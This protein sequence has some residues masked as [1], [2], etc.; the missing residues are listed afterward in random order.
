MQGLTSLLQRSPPPPTN[1]IAEAR[2]VRQ[3]QQRQRRA[4]VPPSP[5]LSS[6]DDRELTSS[7]LPSS[8]AAP[9]PPASP[10]PRPLPS[11]PSDSPCALRVHA[12]LSSGYGRCLF[13]L[14]DGLGVFHSLTQLDPPLARLLPAYDELHA[15]VVALVRSLRQHSIELIV[16][17][18][19]SSTESTK[20]GEL[21]RRCQ[22][23]LDELVQLSSYL[24]HAQVSSFAP[25]TTTPPPL[26]SQCFPSLSMQAMHRQVAWSLRSQRVC[27]VQC[28]DEA[29]ARLSA[30]CRLYADAVWAVLSND[31]DCACMTGVRW[32][33]EASLTIRWVEAQPHQRH[34][35]VQVD[36]A[37]RRHFAAERSQ[38]YSRTT[39][40][41]AHA[42]HPLPDRAHAAEQS[43]PS[44][45]SGVEARPLTTPS[46][47]SPASPPSFLSRPPMLVVQWVA[48]RVWSNSAVSAA[49]RLP[50]PSLL[51]PLSVLAGNDW[52]KRLVHLWAHLQPRRIGAAPIE[53]WVHFL[54]QPQLR[55]KRLEE[56]PAFAALLQQ[57]S[58]LRRAMRHTRM[59]Y[60]GMGTEEEEQRAQ[61]KDGDGV[62]HEPASEVAAAVSLTSALDALRLRDEEL[63][64]IRRRIALGFF[65]PDTLACIVR[66]Y[67]TAHTAHGRHM[68]LL[69]L[70]L[71]H[72]HC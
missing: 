48:C 66:S 27:V 65:S 28:E 67:H 49:L 11:C 58:E 41:R 36:D 56:L 6:S 51:A 37:M 42:A 57:S 16:Y 72:S 29:D 24:D 46:A 9:L 40:P 54:T 71:M 45:W 70:L 62:L 18:D 3:Q 64:L 17:F 52:T 32:I 19:S 47:A 8:A 13:L 25:L 50:S 4:V 14:V 59:V 7:G 55:G 44:A 22:G 61:V 35:A 20:K 23:R 12:A 21:S 60:E 31:S 39:Q 5:H 69:L 1:L 10:R 53:R 2:R 30:D 34:S 43:A 15:R 33:P 26:P 38:G 63:Q 68:P